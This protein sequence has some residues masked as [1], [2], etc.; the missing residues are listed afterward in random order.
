V[1]YV[2]EIFSK[3]WGIEHRIPDDDGYVSGESLEEGEMSPEEWKNA[4]LAICV[5]VGI[6]AIF[7]AGSKV[8]ARLSYLA[9]KLNFIR[10]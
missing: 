3:Y 8:P 1:A 4:Q 5:T 10:F 9:G 6:F 7:L 2:E